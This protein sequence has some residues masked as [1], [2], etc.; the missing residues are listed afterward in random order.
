M[1]AY[2][3]HSVRREVSRLKAADYCDAAVRGV[4]EKLLKEKGMAGPAQGGGGTGANMVGIWGYFPE[5]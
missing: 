3:E 4:A 1:P 2:I 5:Q